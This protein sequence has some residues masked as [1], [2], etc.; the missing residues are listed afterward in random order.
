MS[1]ANVAPTVSNLA[2]DTSVNEGATQ[3]TYTYDI[4]DPGLLDTQTASPSCGRRCV[5]RPI[6]DATS[7]PGRQ[8]C[9]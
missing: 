3:H 5:R 1:V 4:Y 9:A 6:F 8:R 2:G 7:P